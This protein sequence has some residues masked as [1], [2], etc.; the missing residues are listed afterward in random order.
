MINTRQDYDYWDPTRKGF[1]TNYPNF[2]HWKRM[3]A[4]QITDGRPLNIYLHT[5]YCIQRCSYC[6]YKTVNLENSD[7]KDR[8]ARYVDALCREIALTSDYYHLKNRPVI[9]VY[10]GGGTPS[11]LDEAHLEQ[12]VGTLHDHF[13]IETPEFTMEAEPVTLSSAKAERM[14]AL[15]VNRIS[16]GIQ[17]F[18]D[19]IIKGS[20]R[21]DS[22]RKAL[23]AIDIAKGTGATINID[24]MSGLAGETPET[25]AHSVQR[26]IGTG[27][28]SVTV[29]KTELY[30]N[31]AYYQGIRNNTLELPSDDEEMRYMQHAMEQLQ[32]ADYLPW[33]FYNF[34]KR[35]GPIHVHAPSTFRGDD[36]CAFGI[37]AFGRLDQWLYQNTNDEQKYIEQVAAGQLPIQ[38]GYNLTSLDDMI[39]DV[40]LS[41]KLVSLDLAWFQHKHG[42]KLQSLCAETLDRLTAEEFVS[43]T[44]D[45]LRLTPK[46]ILHG[47]YTGKSLARSL[48]SHY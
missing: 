4:E 1:V 48:M 29:Y 42:F 18:N 45:E 22:E 3:T 35:G 14:M 20:H 25:W 21:L 9:S 32:Q 2:P 31:T 40:V 5:P 27:V 30:S 36:C 37:S 24:L 10:F 7:R 11:L 39:R 12:I 23:K 15:K 17:S 38:R 34:T 43:V 44:D 33:S 16:M 8:M 26:A 46:G 41:M 6:Y 19:A 28:D 13:R 47:D